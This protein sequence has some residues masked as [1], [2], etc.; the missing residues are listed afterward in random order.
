MELPTK[1]LPYF[2][3]DEGVVINSGMGGVS[4]L[5]VVVVFL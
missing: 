2:T 3:L 4:D 5:Y 1:E